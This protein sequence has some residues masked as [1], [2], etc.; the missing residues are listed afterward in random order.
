MF[1]QTI[2]IKWSQT[3]KLRIGYNFELLVDVEFLK[4]IYQNIPN[5][6]DFLKSKLSLFIYKQFF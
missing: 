2:G 1:L 3:L 5:V 4:N 6:L